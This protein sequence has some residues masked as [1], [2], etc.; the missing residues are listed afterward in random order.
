VGSARA[1]TSGREPEQSL[2][3]RTARQSPNRSKDGRAAR[4]I[5]GGRM[6]SIVVFLGSIEQAHD[7][8]YVVH[9]GGFIVANN[10]GRESAICW[11]GLATSGAA[12]C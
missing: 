2:G 3:R 7:W 10:I 8:E 1:I 11:R 6:P 4:S 5:G 9:G 12:P